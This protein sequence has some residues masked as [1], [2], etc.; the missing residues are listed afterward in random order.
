VSWT[1]AFLSSKITSSSGSAD[2]WNSSSS[3]DPSSLSPPSSSSS[4]FT[5]FLFKVDEEDSL[6]L[7]LEISYRFQTVQK[8]GMDVQSKAFPNFMCCPPKNCLS[9]LMT[10]I[11]C[12][13]IYIEGCIASKQSKYIF[14]VPG[15]NDLDKINTYQ[16]FPRDLWKIPKHFSLFCILRNLVFFLP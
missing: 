5:R 8:E 13:S 14:N 10:E 12:V 2:I 15:F 7:H 11:Y 9:I 4:S 16:V 1:T 6:G 3:S